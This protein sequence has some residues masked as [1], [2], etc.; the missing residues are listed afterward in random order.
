MCYL[1]GHDKIQP[2]YEDNERSIGDMLIPKH[3]TTEAL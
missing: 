3:A 1:V 2:D